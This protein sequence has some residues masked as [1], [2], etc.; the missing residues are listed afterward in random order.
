M[1][2]SY[3]TRPKRTSNE[4]THTFISEQDADM[5]IQ[6]AVAETTINGYRYF[7]TR[8]QVETADI[9]NIDPP[10]IKRLCEMTP[11]MAK[12][13]V[14]VKADPDIARGAAI[15]R[16]EDPIKEAE[17][18]D[19]RRESEN[20]RFTKFE[21]LI[22]DN[23][24]FETFDIHGYIEVFNTYIP[25][26]FDDTVKSII[27]TYNLLTNTSKL[28]EFGLESNYFKSF[29][30]QHIQINHD[31][32]HDTTEYVKPEI[33]AAKVVTDDTSFARFC[34]DMLSLL[35]VSETKLDKS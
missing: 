20:E 24:L 22:E 23:K 35:N 15:A 13:I 31:K 19:A 5:L 25:N 4:D 17:I 10:A 6:N 28:A 8:E 7:A 18:F 21:K 3:T 34:R 14:H 11:D 27:E 1:V 9:Y 30:G 2:K 33:F 16:A 26:A 29:D 12:I 32:N